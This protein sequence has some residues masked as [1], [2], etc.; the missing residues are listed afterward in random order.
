VIERNAGRLQ[1]LVDDILQLGRA[2]EGRLKLTVEPV[3][4]ARLVQRAT[5]SAGPVAERKGLVLMAE[6]APDL[7]ELEGDR[8]LLAQ[9]LDNLVS[10]AIKFT[11]A[12]GTVTI[13]ARAAG[14][15][16]ELEV[17]DSGVGIPADELPHLFDRFF[18]ASTAVAPGTGLG[19][20]IARSIADLHGA[21]ISVD[22]TVGVGSTFRLTL[23]LAPPTA[24]QPRETEKLEA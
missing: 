5:E 9:L 16:V 11:P 8:R 20:T 2:D 23:P 10:N 19:L 15:G 12:G 21:T 18:R 1:Q 24:R 13:R 4:V 14:E 6:V 7:P 17:R 22:S 3:D